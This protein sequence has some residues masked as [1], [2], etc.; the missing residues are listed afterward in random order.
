VN[1]RVLEG[2]RRRL[3]GGIIHGICMEELGNPTIHLALRL[4][5]LILDLIIRSWSAV[6]SIAV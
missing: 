3:A 1:C 2:I 5:T 6:R 4:E